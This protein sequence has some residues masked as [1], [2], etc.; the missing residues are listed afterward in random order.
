MTTATASDGAP[1]VTVKET[2]AKGLSGTNGTNGTGFNI[3]RQSL[4]DNPLLH[5]FGTNNLRQVSAPLN[6]D[7][8]LTFD[9]A[10]TATFLDRYGVLQTAAIDVAREEQPG[11]LIEGASTNEALH[12]RD[13]TNAAWTKT[14]I[15]AAKDATG[16]DGSANAASSLTATAANGT[17]FQSITLSS[18]K[19]TYS[20]DVKRK[21]GTGT[22]EMTDDGGSTFTDI[23]SSI[24]SSTFTRLS[25]TTTQANP[26]IGFRIVTNTDAIEVDFNQLENLPFA[27][28]RIPTT[29]TSVT[30]ATDIV[31]VVGTDNAALLSGNNSILVTVDALGDADVDQFIIAISSDDSLNR[32]LV[33]TTGIDTEVDQFISGAAT[34]AITITDRKNINNLLSTY[35][36]AAVVSYFNGSSSGGGNISYTDDA[37]PTTIYLGDDADSGN[38]LFGHLKDL[39]LYDFV[40]N[41]DEATYLA[42]T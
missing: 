37:I 9:R 16:L 32:S 20:V 40:L 11:W 31:T 13:L 42:G 30:K 36:G 38:S 1:T 18:Q 19:N 27:S 35:N 26:S 25:I 5:L 34:T 21:T 39:R 22:I 12:N 7:A 29:T 15:T 8:D 23:T 14:N 33:F 4:L 28:S 41:S 17:V 3:V 6:T 2:G 10:T 24:N